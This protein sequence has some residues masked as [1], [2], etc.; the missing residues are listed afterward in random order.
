[1]V[2][3]GSIAVFVL[4]ILTMW[5]Q[6]LPLWREGTRW[7]TVS[8]IAFA[9]L[10]PVVPMVFIP[11]GRAFESAL[12]AAIGSGRVT[13]ELGAALHDPVT[14]TARWYELA[15]VAFVIFLMVAKPF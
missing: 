13:T 10:I 3:Y 11:R 14:A 7:V 2:T 15:V 1:M 5:A 4:G 6:G 12:H 9:S 8:L